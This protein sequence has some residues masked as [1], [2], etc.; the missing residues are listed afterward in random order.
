MT[1]SQP[2]DDDMQSNDAQ[3]SDAQPTPETTSRLHEFQ[4]E[5]DSL[6]VGGGRANPERTWLKV[7]IAAWIV[8]IA[9]EIFAWASSHST[10]DA[11]EQRDFIILSVA[12]LTIAVIGTGMFVTFMLTR[13]FRYWL[14]RL[15]YQDRE[16]TDRLLDRLGGR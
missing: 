15:I 13:Y 2:K 14:I 11:L 12:G 3:T 1:S 9:L 16:S 10:E 6:R 7:S 5:V 8:A 4:A